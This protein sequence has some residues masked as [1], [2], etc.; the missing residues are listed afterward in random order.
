MAKC[1]EHHTVTPH[2]P[3]PTSSMVATHL[4]LNPALV[5]AG[6]AS[7]LAETGKTLSTAFSPLDDSI[8]VYVSPLVN[9]LLHSP[10][11]EWCLIRTHYTDE[12]AAK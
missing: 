8:C 7:E 6:K 2:H 12:R 3:S 11:T 1:V 9:I 4:T 5:D 10:S